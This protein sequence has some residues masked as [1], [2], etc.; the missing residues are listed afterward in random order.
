MF[1][2]SALRGASRRIAAREEYIFATKNLLSLHG[3]LVD[4]QAP[5]V[6]VPVSIS[7]GTNFKACGYAAM[8]WDFFFS[9]SA[10]NFTR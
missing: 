6:W 3:L 2:Y 8:G 7:E 10:R 9:K 5:C 1:L 4:S